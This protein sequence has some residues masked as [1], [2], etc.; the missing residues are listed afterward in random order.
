MGG[1]PTNVKGEVLR[2]GVNVVKGLYAAGEVACVSVHGSNRLGTNSLLDINVFGKRSGRAAAE[3]AK[4]ASFHELP[5]DPTVRVVAQLDEM[6]NRPDGERVADIRKALQESMDL[7]AQVFRTGESLND[8]LA[9]IRE[10]QK[11]YRNA[12]VQDK[13][14]L[15]NTDLLEAIELGFLLD[16]AEVTVVAAIN[17]KESRGGH[18]REDF[19]NRDD[20]HYMLHTM[21]YRRPP[22]ASDQAEGHIEG[23]F[24]HVEEFDG[25]KVVLGSKPVIQT[26]YEPMERKY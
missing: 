18:Y 15:F 22:E 12:S 3:Y 17:R 9:D 25:Y 6:R 13:G 20:A 26:R 10:L 8:A 4:T 11:R 16:I 14:K 7:N 21:A 23:Y 2:D 1:V 19:P 24:D 5:E